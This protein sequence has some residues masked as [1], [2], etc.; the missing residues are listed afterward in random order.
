MPSPLANTEEWTVGIFSSRERPETLWSVVQAAKAACKRHSAVIDVLINGNA[1]LANAIASVA[2][3]RWESADQR[4]RLRVWSFAV[5]DKSLVW[6]TYVHQML[7]SSPVAFFL[8]GYAEVCP[9]ALQVMADALNRDD[10]ALAATGVPTMGPSA[11]GLQQTLASEGG[12]HGN[13]YALKRS[14]VHQVREFN[15]RLPRGLYR[16]DPALGA[17]VC[18]N[19]D[20]RGNSWDSKRIAVVREATWT[21]EP[22]VPW[23]WQHWKSLSK[24]RMRQAQGVAENAAMRR[25]FSIERK[26]VGSL[27]DTAAQLVDDW[28]RAAPRDATRLFASNPLTWLACR[29]LA[30]VPRD[31]ASAV[32]IRP[33]LVFQSAR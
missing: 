17:A 31:G 19:F 12:I 23:K 25:L 6:N 30:S 8:D 27:P 26:P 20:P 33:N 4:V 15:F 24:R 18:F 21:Y 9:E 7:P 32:M 16:T 13:L 5:A 22:P 10:R 11:R 1:Q 28:R 14:C 3:E 29:R 2:A